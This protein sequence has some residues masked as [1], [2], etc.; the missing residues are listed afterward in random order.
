MAEMVPAE[1]WA[2]ATAQVKEQYP[3]I[4][5]IGEVYNPGDYRRYLASGFDLLY[6]KV[7]MYDAM[8]DVLC[9]RRDTHSL[10][11]AWQQTDDIGDHMLYFLENHDEQRLAS[12]FFA[13]QAEKGLP[14][15]VVSVLM[16][17]N[18]FMLYA[19]QEW[20]ERGMDSEGFS[21]CDGRTT[22]FDYWSLSQPSQQEESPLT[23]CYR[24]VL[25][26]A[27]REKAVSQGTFFDLMYVNPHLRRQYAFLRSCQNNPSK[28]QKNSLL[29]VVAN[30]DD[31]PVTVSVCIPAHAFSYLGIR[32]GDC[33]ATDLLSG[34]IRSLTLQ[35]DHSV[36][37]T[38]APRGAVVLSV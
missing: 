31:V 9:H 17:Q 23:A 35:P 20:G 4:V 34:N 8:R 24:Q 7:G 5:F 12:D 14:A 3:G 11:W 22:I 6:D 10:T 21:G 16:R 15:L 13:G 18:P 19:G 30:F 1:F 38:L 27:R 25:T 29:L 33:E 32:A 2:W 37:V 36:S 26:I 28:R